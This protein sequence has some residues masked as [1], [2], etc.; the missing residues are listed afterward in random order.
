VLAATRRAP[1]QGTRRPDTQALVASAN[2][3]IVVSRADHPPAPLTMGGRAIE[4]DKATGLG[5]PV[6]ELAPRL[7]P[8]RPLQDS[9]QW[10]TG[11]SGRLWQF[12]DG[13]EHGCVLQGVQGV[14]RLGNDQQVAVAPFPLDGVSS[15]AY[16]TM[17]H[18]DSG[19]AGVLVF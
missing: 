14:P 6:L 17:Q 13:E 1:D 5:L 19:L 18:V 11:Y 3:L 10:P 9:R 4:Q 16:P 15:K 8:E 7:E 2:S 12:G